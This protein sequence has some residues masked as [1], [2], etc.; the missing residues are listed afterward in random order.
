[1]MPYM[2]TITLLMTLLPLLFLGA[3]M[4]DGNVKQAIK[5]SFEAPPTASGSVVTGACY[6]DQYAAPEN[7]IVRK[8]DIAIV[9]DTSGSIQDERAAIGAGFD[10]F[11][12]QL[13]SEVDF[14]IG[15]ILAHGDKT[16]RTGKLYK[17][18][19]SEPL[20][21]ASDLHTIDEIKTHLRNKMQ[22]P[23]GDGETDGG[24]LGLYSLQNAISGDNLVNSQA[25]G[26]F[27]DDAALAVVFVAD[28][29]DICAK[30]PEGVQ[31]VPDPQ[32]GENASFNKYC[33]D[34]EGNYLITP[35][36]ILSQ[37][38]TLKGDYPLVV[39]GVLYNN[40]NTMATVD[41][42]EL[43]YGYLE[44]VDLAAG[45]TVDMASGDYA[46]GLSRLGRLATIKLA[47]VN[48]FALA[49]NRVE[50]S[51]IEV[52]LEGQAIAH[53]YDAENNIV[54][55]N[56]ERDPFSVVNVKYCEKQEAPKEVQKLAAGGDHT[57]ALLVSGKVKCWGK[58]NF[59][60]L[61]LGHTNNIGDDELPSSGE[62]I[63][64]GEAKVVDISAGLQHTCAI[65]EDG[66]VRCWGENMMGQ[67]GLGH[68]DPIGDNELPM[69]VG[70]VPLGR[71]AKKI[72]SG[73][74]YNCALLDNR[75]IKC[76]GQNNFGQLGYGDTENRGDDESIESL[77]YVSVGAD[78]VAMDISTISFHACAVLMSGDLKCWGYNAFGQLGYGH[79]NN[80]GDDEYP[81]DVGTVP[82]GTQV[83]QIASGF[84]HTC[85]LTGGQSIRCWGSNAFGQIGTG[86]SQTIGDDEAADSI[87]FIATGASS[88]LMV[89]TGNFHT[90]AVGSNG[91]VYCFGQSTQGQIGLGTTSNLGDN[92]TVE[93]V[94]KVNLGDIKI[95]Q[96]AAG[97]NHTCA[98]SKDEGKVICWGANASGQLGYGH[99]NTLGDN[100]SSL[101]NFITLTASE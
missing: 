69:S 47:P 21:L 35:E 74:R 25:E 100:E 46:D 99:K 1:M 61:G 10:A 33:V 49:T 92:E 15:V 16:G 5:E 73:T 24:E 93:N 50:P 77:G 76:W 97:T 66:S 41:E 81:S 68:T 36:S 60:Q 98:L 71:P 27:R 72:Y 48:S 101:G 91:G 52:L 75:K 42:N 19:S 65:F 51:T 86:N 55:I 83:L 38:Q 89:A 29:N 18:Y 82:F 56:V 45:I 37:L 8:L 7:E 70:I 30:Y 78:V 32:G 13:P 44:T 87:G 88:H 11:I 80:I 2:K 67:L 53:A 84:R 6:N 94:S 43:G 28:E 96:V 90:C 63:D 12:D 57:C 40:L 59:G 95:S 39:G 34:S 58:N 20:V 3:C 17:K 14:R 26:F 22:Y 85:A 9:I 4:E 54:S 79:T 31:P 62:T 64:F 23:A